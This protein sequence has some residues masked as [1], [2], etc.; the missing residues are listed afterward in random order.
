VDC[1]ACGQA[2]R[3]GAA[4]CDACGA[5]LV[6]ACPSC[7]AANRPGAKFCDVCGTSL[8]TTP[9]QTPAHL[10][11]KIL[12]E[13]GRIEG[14][15]RT[16]TVLFADA[17]GFTPLSERLGEE[18][19]YEF[20]QRCVE[21][22]VAGVHRH[23]GTVTQ[24]TGDGIVALFGAPIAH[25]DS[26]R[27]AV[28]AA[29]EIQRSL[30]DY[31]DGAQIDTAFRIGLN[32]GPV[33]VGRISDD[34]S[35]D[36]TA[37]GDTVNLAARMEQ[38]CEPGSVFLTENTHRQVVEYFDFEDV[39]LTDVKG[40][41]APVHIYK[42][43]GERDVRT[44]LDAAIARGLSPFTGRGRE[45]DMLKNFWNDALSAR[46]Q[47][48]LISGEPGIG[49]SRLLLEFKRSLAADVVWREAQCVP[50]GEGI[51][52]LPV[53][54]LVRRGFGVTETDDEG[55]II[56]KVDVDTTDWTPAGQKTVPYLKFLLQVDP[57]DAAVE[58]MG[59]LERRAGILDA[60]RALI[61]ERS[62][63]A[64][65][66]VV[67]ED[68][69]WADDASEEAFRVCADVVAASKVLMIL[70]FRPGYLHPSA[71]LPHAHRIVLNDLDDDAR[72]ALASATL[73]ASD[74]SADLA[75]PVTSKAE[76]NP[77]FI[78]EVAKALAAGAADTSDVPDSLQDVILARIDRLEAQAR[79]ALQ[80]ASVIGREFT[81]RLLNRI[82]DLHA[83]L[84]GVLTGLKTLELIYEKAFFPE[85][86]YMFKHALTHD[87]AYSTLLVER[88]KTLHRVVASAIEELYTDRI[89]EHYETL[90]HHYVQAEAWEKAIDYL[91]KSAEKA[92][93]AYAV[94]DAASYYERA[95]EICE[96]LG[97]HLR[98]A[99]I[100]HRRGMVHLSIF[101]IPDAIGDFERM[102]RSARTANDER[103][104]ARALGA[105]GVA[106]WFAHEFEA[107]AAS[108]RGALDIAEARFPEAEFDANM[109]LAG[110]HVVTGNI[111]QGRLAIDKLTRLRGD[112]SELQF[113]SLSGEIEVLQSNWRGD[114]DAAIA[115][116]ERWMRELAPHGAVVMV[117]VSWAGA[118]ALGGR[119]EYERAL[120]VLDDVI[121]TCE[122]TSALPDF[123]ARALNTVGWIYGELHDEARALEWSERGLQLA[124]AISSADP[125]FEN[126]AILNVGDA[127]LASGDLDGAAEQY[128]EVERVARHPRP[129]DRW[130]LWRYSQHLFHSS[131]EMW[132][133]RG[134][135]DRAIG[136]ADEC[137]DGA[138]ASSSR[139]NLIKGHRLRGRALMQRRDLEEAAHELDTALTLARKI[140][141]PP[142]LWKTL[143]AAGD[144]A[145]VRG[146][147]GDRY[148]REASSTIDS[149]ASALADTDRREAFLGSRHISEIR[150]KG[151]AN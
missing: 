46:G 75:G 53:V 47:I 48:V 26:A 25:E 151:P 63:V 38:M 109:A 95:L 17:K 80:L 9:V 134:D 52:Y 62:R 65:R 101:A 28:A 103:L 149:M 19:M 42:A 37:V 127:L 130:M 54:D 35:M 43:T 93:E 49:K 108:A 112:D 33:V 129:L 36:Y 82:S 8:Q 79:E 68:L 15:R 24:F 27:R 41:S 50:Y 29:L 115:S 107:A 121:A 34:L 147:D 83:Q 78:E 116:Y 87:V 114:F 124:R 88:R 67:V 148:Y 71:D 138:K 143:E 40:K 144:L 89:A 136:Y 76:G 133:A 110:V 98:V 106:E 99:E 21:L 90:A 122:R 18:K 86:A 13:R 146:S 51:P 3:E 84:E 102:L 22:M 94:N 118:V 2:N 92:V 59:P 111:E 100:A 66:V 16:V 132:L 97:L 39:G 14:E 150:A 135:E 140:G 91:A 10:A 30:G 61:L 64:P 77:L 69:H 139:K 55:A 131:G 11:R 23:E 74:L 120:R 70:T 44:R 57:G 31:I 141:N 81:L 85:L 7:G 58:T 56:E 32:T 125:E 73:E 60:L 4:F 45:L 145:A 126:N 128:D 12:E 113:V 96:R 117:P 1:P 119:G 72:R 123:L 142:Q 105:R 137:I 20:V 5:S 6:A 104:E